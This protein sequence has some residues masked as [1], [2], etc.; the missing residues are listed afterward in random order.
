MSGPQLCAHLAAGAASKVGQTAKARSGY[1]VQSLRKGRDRQCRTYLIDSHPDGVVKSA[2]LIDV[3]MLS[4]V[5]QVKIAQSAMG[6]TSK[7]QGPRPQVFDHS[8]GILGTRSSRVSL[9]QSAAI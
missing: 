3:R 7:A 9:G 6:Q 1:R 8:R 2:R 4:D 5:D